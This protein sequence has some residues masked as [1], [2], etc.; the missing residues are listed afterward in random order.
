MLGD[1]GSTGKPREPHP[2][3]PPII[4]P[5]RMLLSSHCFL[6]AILPSPP[7]PLSAWKTL[8]P[9]GLRPGPLAGAW[10]GYRQPC[11]RMQDVQKC[12]AQGHR[13]IGIHMHLFLRYRASIPRTQAWPSFRQECAPPKPGKMIRGL[14]PFS[15]AELPMPRTQSCPSAWMPKDPFLGCRGPFP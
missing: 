12:P 2:L 14:Q 7:G 3:L 4:V 10:S 8:P 13:G 6:P 1:N 15:P 5:S 9:R 11:L